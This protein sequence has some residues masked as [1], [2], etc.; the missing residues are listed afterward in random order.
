MAATAGYLCGVYFLAF[1]QFQAY[2]F[3]GRSGGM[4]YVLVF[5]LCFVFGAVVARW[6]VVCFP[7]VHFIGISEF[8]EWMSTQPI[9][10]DVHPLAA[11]AVVAVVMSAGVLTGRQI[12][13]R[14][15]A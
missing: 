12:Q 1:Y 3:G 11:F 7:A 5:M 6:W 4:Y 10:Y 14:E 13:P 8:N 9:D 2:G 15:T